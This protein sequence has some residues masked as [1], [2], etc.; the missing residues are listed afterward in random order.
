MVN[1]QWKD[2]RNPPMTLRCRDVSSYPCPRVRCPEARYSSESLGQQIKQLAQVR[3]EVGSRDHRKMGTGGYPCLIH[4]W[5]VGLTW[6]DHH[7]SSSYWGITRDGTPL[8]RAEEEWVMDV[9]P[10]ESFI[11]CAPSQGPRK[12]IAWWIALKV[13][14]IFM[15]NWFL[16][17]GSFSDPGWNWSPDHNSTS[18]TWWKPGGLGFQWRRE[19][20]CAGGPQCSLVSKSLHVSHGRLQKGP[21]WG[22]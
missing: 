5:L 22:K 20:Q 14:K 12:F 15:W 6:I 9:R 13:F 21:G 7:K 11:P 8:R 17:F 16:C 1:P 18:F 2:G 4:L 19:V 3:S 10:S